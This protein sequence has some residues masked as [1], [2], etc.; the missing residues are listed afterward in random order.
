MIGG[1][2]K[3]GST[4][5]FKTRIQYSHQS[6]AEGEKRIIKIPLFFFNFSFW[7]D[8]VKWNSIIMISKG[9]YYVI[10]V[11]IVSNV[12]IS[13]DLVYPG[14]LARGSTVVIYQKIYFL[15]DPRARLSIF[16]LYPRAHY[17]WWIL[18]GHNWNHIYKVFVF[19]FPP[20]LSILSIV[21]LKSPRIILFS[22]HSVLFFI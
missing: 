8:Y 1:I 11:G 22:F 5:F 14:S 15:I 7:M 13:I 17:P 18:T 20:S 16:S 9:Y 2:V 6:L 4:V 19:F 12:Y 21:Q 10:N 3:K